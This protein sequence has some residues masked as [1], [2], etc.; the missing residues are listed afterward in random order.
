MADSS[1]S[2]VTDENTLHQPDGVFSV[3]PTKAADI[4][5]FSGMDLTPPPL[6]GEAS[7]AG[8]LYHPGR[9]LSAR[10][11]AAGRVKR[12][13]SNKFE[14]LLV[15]LR[16]KDPKPTDSFEL[17]LGPGLIRVADVD[18]REEN[19]NAVKVN[20]GRFLTM[21]TLKGVVIAAAVVCV[22]TMI[23]IAIHTHFG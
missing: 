11:L 15:S 2:P 9:R 4:L 8:A 1:A 5:T 12:S 10:K 19:A 7:L 14:A 22:A 6:P 18:T 23:G 3:S 21:K 16:L 17:Q 20:W 13:V